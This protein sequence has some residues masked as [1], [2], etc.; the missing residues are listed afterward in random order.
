MEDVVR[1]KRFNNIS[2]AFRGLK[3]TKKRLPYFSSVVYGP[4]I[5]FEQQFAIY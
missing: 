1:N 5:N 4:E 2:T 3:I